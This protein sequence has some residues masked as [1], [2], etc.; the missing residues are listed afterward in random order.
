MEHSLAGRFAVTEGRCTIGGQF[1]ERNCSV[2]LSKKSKPETAADKM[3]KLTT[4]VACR[5][6]RERR[7]VHK[8]NE[9]FNALKSCL[10]SLK[11][12]T[13]RVSKLKILRSAIDYIRCLQSC[14]PEEASDQLPPA[15]DNA[16]YLNTENHSDSLYCFAAYHKQQSTP[17]WDTACTFNLCSL[18]VH[19]Q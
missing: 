7:R 11:Q 12:R 1:E 9:A 18:H 5:N 17:Y 14:L 19:L 2:R 8:V 3:H 13:R 15:F 4:A 10:P 6:A 16:N